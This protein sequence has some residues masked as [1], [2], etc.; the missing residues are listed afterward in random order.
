METILEIGGA[1]SKGNAPSTVETKPKLL[2]QLGT[3]DADSNGNAPSSH[4][5]DLGKILK[6][7]RKIQKI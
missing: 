2:E 4:V 7:G 3:L 5:E 1:S 6:T